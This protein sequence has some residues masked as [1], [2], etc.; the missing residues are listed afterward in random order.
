[1]KN[2]SEF[3]SSLSNTLEYKN[4]DVIDKFCSLYSVSE[5]EA[6]ILFEELKKWL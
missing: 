5:I 3:P 1:M 6:D 4:Q 2:D